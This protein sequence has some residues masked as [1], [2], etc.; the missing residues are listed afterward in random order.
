[1][2]DRALAVQLPSCPV[3]N[4]N[5]STA[6]RLLPRRS[7]WARPPNRRDRDDQAG[8]AANHTIEVNVYIFV[9]VAYVV[10]G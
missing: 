3:F 7:A 9:D 5:I 10:M 1:M 6:D 4:V 8:R 2:P